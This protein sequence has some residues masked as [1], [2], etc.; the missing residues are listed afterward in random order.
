MS[1]AK[2]TYF[3]PQLSVSH[4]AFFIFYFS[5]MVYSKP[6]V[7]LLFLLHS[8]SWNFDNLTIWLCTSSVLRHQFRTDLHL[9]LRLWIFGGTS[10]M[11][12]DRTY[13]IVST[14]E[15]F[16]PIQTQKPYNGK[17]MFSSMFFL[18]LL[19]WLHCWDL[20]YLGD[21]RRNITFSLTFVSLRKG[22][23]KN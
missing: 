2:Q 19:N 10:R 11:G 15:Y 6:S 16:F 1:C 13:I 14:P 17:W 4:T 3:F 12:A 5:W 20:L 21:W 8:L 23:D 18:T 7:G 9:V 22:C